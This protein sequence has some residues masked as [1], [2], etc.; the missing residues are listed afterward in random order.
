MLERCDREGVSAY[1]DA[2]SPDNKRLYE[3]HGFRAGAEYAP[4]GG[5]PFWPMWREPSV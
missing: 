1:L 5:P 3:R 2:P 4:E